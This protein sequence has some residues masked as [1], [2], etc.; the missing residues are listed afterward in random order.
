MPG[1]TVPL[2]IP[3][4]IASDTAR[5]AMQTIPQAAAEKVDDLL[6]A[7]SGFNPG[8]IVP[9]LGSN[10]ESAGEGSAAYRG[11]AFAELTLYVRAAGPKAAASTIATL[12]VGWRPPRIVRGLMSTTVTNHVA[13]TL[14]P[15]GL[16][17]CEVALTT[18]TLLYGNLTFPV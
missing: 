6:A 8:S 13:V 7:M 9:V 11:A 14:T 18:G 4:P 15:A 3:Y 5:A 12:P 16:F 2:N 10:I 17:Y 1:Y